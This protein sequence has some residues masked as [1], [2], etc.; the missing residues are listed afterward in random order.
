METQLLKDKDVFPSDEGLAA[1][2]LGEERHTVAREWGSM[3]P[4]VFDVRGEASVGDLL[5]V[6]EFKKRAK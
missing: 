6:V 1:L 2:G 4:L 5:R 3:I